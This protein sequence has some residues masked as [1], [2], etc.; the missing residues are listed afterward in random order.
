MV[1]GL[2]LAYFCMHDAE[3]CVSLVSSL[4]LSFKTQIEHLVPP[5]SMIWLLYAQNQT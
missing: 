4:P 2:P 1:L 5:V 3:L